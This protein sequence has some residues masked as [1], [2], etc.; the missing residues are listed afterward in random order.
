MILRLPLR[1]RSGPS[2]DS[3]FERLLL[4]VG[5]VAPIAAWVFTRWGLRTPPCLFY[6]F[7]GYPCPSCGA[8]RALR[9]VVMGDL[10]G[11]FLLNPLAFAVMLAGLVAVLYASSVVLIG[12][13]PW[14]PKV[15]RLGW[16]GLR[17]VMAVALLANE[18]YLVRNLP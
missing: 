2:R 9:A 16:I 5:L 15:G 13:S 7:T 8:T 4:V 6:E 3:R 17:M 10:R 1:S 14:R 12:L 11:A 18:W